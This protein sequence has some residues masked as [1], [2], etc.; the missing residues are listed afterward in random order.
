MSILMVYLPFINIFSCPFTFAFFASRPINTL[1]WNILKIIYRHFSF[2]AFKSRHANLH[3]GTK[4]KSVAFHW[5]KL[6]ESEKHLKSVVPRILRAKLAVVQKEIKQFNDILEYN[7]NNVKRP[8]NDRE[9]TENEQE[10]LGTTENDKVLPIENDWKL[11]RLS[12]H[13]DN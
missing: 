6:W 11:P 2:M 12:S 13:R 5:K 10:R 9:T 3:F 1:F 8:W 4:I 7:V